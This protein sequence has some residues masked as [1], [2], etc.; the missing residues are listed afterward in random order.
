MGYSLNAIIGYYFLFH[1]IN[2]PLNFLAGDLIRRIG[3]RWVIVLSNF[4]IIGYF[5]AFDFLTVDSF[6]IL[7]ALAF[8]GALYDALYWV[9]HLYLFIKSNDDPKQTNGKTGALY[10]AKQVA[11]M[12]GPIAGAIILAFGSQTM[13]LAASI[14]LFFASIIPLIYV[15]TF[16]DKPT[17]WDRFSSFLNFFKSPVEK[18]NFITN[19]LYSIHNF[20]ELVLWPIFIFLI[21][22]SI[23]SVAVIPVLIAATTIIFS[24]FTR[25]INARTRE[26]LIMTGALALALIWVIRMTIDWSPFYYISIVLVGIFALFVSIPLDSNLFIRA[27]RIDPL[28][29]AVLKNVTAMSVK[30]FLFAGIFLFANVF[31]IAF[32]IT[33]AALLILAAVNFYF[34]TADSE[35]FDAILG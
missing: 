10:S 17:Q 21:F 13:L 16:S 3:A 26:K 12:M 9:A 15:N 34:M 11:T 23:E 32:V 6:V 19:G 31:E 2:V 27:R 22:Q 7:I 35:D 30:L 28:K 1:L 24:L 33:I 14:T 8:L 18:N 20:S 4:A 29:T 25:R 5:I